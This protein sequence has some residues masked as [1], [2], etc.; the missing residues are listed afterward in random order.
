V[1]KPPPAPSP[2]AISIGY[3]A[4]TCR[5]PRC[6]KGKLYRGLLTIADNCP[7]CGLPLKAYEQG[8]GPAFFGILII[9]TLSAVF[10]AIIEIKFAPPFW[11]HALLWGPFVIIGSIVSLRWLKAALVAVQY[12]YR[13]HEPLPPE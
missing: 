2:P 8:D 6:G 3:A 4:L 13:K 11:L 1:N 5:C 12:R 10:A 9:G 7:S